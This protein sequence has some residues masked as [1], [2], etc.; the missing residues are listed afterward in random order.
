MRHGWIALAVWLLGSWPLGAQ[1]TSPN[2]LWPESAE[3]QTVAQ[4]QQ[5][6]QSEHSSDN[7]SDEDCCF[8]AHC[9]ELQALAAAAYKNPFYKNDFS[10]LED[11]HYQPQLL[12]ERLKRLAAPW[13]TVLDLGGQYR[14]RFHNEQ[15]HR[16]LGLTGRDDT[17]L[18]HRLRLFANWEVT[19]WA[20]V[21]LEYRDAVSEFEQFRPRR[22]EENRSDIL[23]LFAEAIVWENGW[24]QLGARVGR[25]EYL[26][27]T[28]RL[29]SPLDWSNTR[30]TFDGATLYWRGE[31]WDIDGFWTRPVYPDA[32]NFDNPDNSQQFFGVYCTYKNLRNAK[33]ELYY[34]NF[35]EDAGS[36]DFYFNTL[37]LR[38]E[39]HRAPWHMEVEAAYQFGQFGAV[40]HSAGAYTVGLGRDLVMLPRTPQ[41]WVFFDWASGDSVQGNGF[42][43]LFPLGHYYLGF[44]DLFGR[45]NLQTVNILYKHQL[46]PKWRLLLWWYVFWLQRTDDVPYSVTMT[47]LVSTPGGSR[48]LG[49]EL[50][51]IVG[52]RIS[53]RMDLLVGFSYF[54]AGKFWATNPSPGIFNGDAH[55]TYIQW[56]TNF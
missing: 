25:Q 13:G 2:P 14:M 33:L 54:W 40:D 32:R 55:F 8:Q 37:G 9:E 56:I 51:L 23:N 34:L 45:R 17:F 35:S 28:E 38:Y 43:H 16:G 15:N 31:N 12:G 30:R 6:S 46:A 53:P 3:V 27:G 4:E 21:Y 48:E 26:F 20:R 10:Y 42:H 1:E 41:L 18:L 47:P 19:P 49:Q 29:V 5:V 52:Y 11:P 22:I 24:G 7:P 39:A 44:I 36:P 50:D